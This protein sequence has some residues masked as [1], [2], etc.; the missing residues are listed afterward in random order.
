M[1]PFKILKMLQTTKQVWI[2]LFKLLGFLYFVIL[3]LLNPLLTI[4]LN[5]Q[6]DDNRYFLV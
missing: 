1:G 2:L 4:E 3:I 6:E 5:K